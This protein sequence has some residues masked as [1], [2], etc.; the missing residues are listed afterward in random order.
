MRS[1]IPPASV[2]FKLKTMVGNRLL[3]RFYRKQV[4]ALG[5]TRHLGP[6]PLRLP[7]LLID[8]GHP[9]TLVNLHGFTDRKESF[10][11][12]ARGL[13]DDF[14]LVLPD[15]P[16]FGE[17]V[18]D[19]SCSYTLDHYTHAVVDLIHSLGLPPVWLCGNSLGGAVASRVTFDRPDLVRVSLPISPTLY[20]NDENNPLFEEFSRGENLFL[21][22]TK[23]DYSRYVGRIF[24]SRPKRVPLISDALFADMMC[25]REWY[26]KLA[27]DL[28][29]GSSGAPETLIQAG[30]FLNDRLRDS[31]VPM[32]FLWGEHD[33]LFPSETVHT[34]RRIRPDYKYTVLSN[35]GHCPHLEAPR[36]LAMAICE[37]RGWLQSR[38]TPPGPAAP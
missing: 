21:V 1:T 38:V 20:H 27:E 37:T 19:P 16:G 35:S 2:V 24:H 22:Y 31:T 8:R 33:S 26:R 7:Y 18:Q 4:S 14:N 3:A 5:A 28:S 12:C 25:K 36:K 10:L 9:D 34:L 17:T 30:R 32:H 13:V 15:M 29:E 6:P 23:E 11:L